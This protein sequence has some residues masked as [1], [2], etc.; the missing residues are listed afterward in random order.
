M[1]N[2]VILT[3]KGGLAVTVNTERINFF[4]Q[5]VRDGEPPYTRIFMAGDD[6]GFTVSEGPNEVLAAIRNA[7]AKHSFDFVL[8]NRFLNEAYAEFE[9]GKQGEPQLP[10]RRRTGGG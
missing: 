5:E 2:E 3:F 6:C 10:V 8:A 9:A 1:F 7:R 4:K